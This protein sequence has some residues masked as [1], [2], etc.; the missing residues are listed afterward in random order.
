MVTLSE[1]A[2]LNDIAIEMGITRGEWG[3]GVASV[4]LEIAQK[5]CNKGGVAHGGIY[6]MMLDMALGGALV[7][8]LPVE[9]W[10]ATTQ[11][12]TS[13]ISSAKPGE[14]ITSRGKVVKRGRNV[15]HLKG[16]ITTA[17]GRVVANAS[18]TWAIWDHK[19]ESMG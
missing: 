7:S 18:G 5:H 17:S 8:I 12:S 2:Q 15:A 6:T 3:N 19:P 14:R 13:F 4:E 1:P 9:E 10:C 11:L 16:E